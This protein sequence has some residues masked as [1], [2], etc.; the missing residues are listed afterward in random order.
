ML[1]GEGSTME[2]IN[3]LIAIGYQTIDDLFNI[4]IMKRTTIKYSNLDDGDDQS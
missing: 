1:Q 2:E 4:S 3:T